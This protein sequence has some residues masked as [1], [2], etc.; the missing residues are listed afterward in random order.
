MA[1]HNGAE[2][3]PRTLSALARLD[4][5]PGGWRLV[6]VDSG[7]TDATPG[8]IEA[9]RG[10]LP[11]HAVRH[12][13][14]GKNAA[15]NAGLSRV[16][17]D[18]VAFTD[19][20]VVPAQD[21]LV[22]LRAAA[23]RNPEHTVFGGAILPLWPRPPEPWITRAVPL[24]PV[25]SLTDPTQP[26]GPIGW[27]LVWGPNMMVRAEVFAGGLR[28]DEAVGPDGTTTYRMGSESSFT[29]ML[30]DL[31]HRCWH[32][33]DA[34]VQ[35]VIR[36]HQLD[37]AWILGRAY[38]FGRSKAQHR[39]A[40]PGT[41]RWLGVPRWLVRQGAS[42]LGRAALARLRGD[43]DEA[44]RRAWDFYFTA[45]LGYELRQQAES[46]RRPRAAGVLAPPSSA[47]EQQES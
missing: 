38:R 29:E 47:P 42:A 35:H 5:P 9:H 44:F 12:P 20:D 43:R 39:M 33:A 21:W 34:R 36:P 30:A 10:A 7:S 4:S 45:G 37:R 41:P 25:Y 17:G 2:R 31:G 28:F 26:E 27:W 1:S 16:E 15:L 46:R 8:V 24:G 22:Q 18:L 14:P 3:L 13:R 23:G 32:A 19:D 40:P 6:V 11:L